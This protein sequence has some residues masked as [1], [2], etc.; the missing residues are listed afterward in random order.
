[1]VWWPEGLVAKGGPRPE[2]PIPRSLRLS[3][4]GLLA[5]MLRGTQH[6][7]AIADG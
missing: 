2:G 3:G 1:M 5:T 4:R 6:P 7:D